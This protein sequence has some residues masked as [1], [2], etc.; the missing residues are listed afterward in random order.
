MPKKKTSI[1]IVGDGTA[2]K[3]AVCAALNDLYESSTVIEN[4]A[5]VWPPDDGAEDNSSLR[6]IVT[7]IV[8]TATVPLTVF[9]ESKSDI[10]KHIASEADEIVESGSPIFAACSSVGRNVT[11]LVL[12]NDDNLDYTEKV[13]LFL[14]QNGVKEILDL[15]NALVPIVVEDDEA[16]AE[17]A[18]PKKE[19]AEAPKAEKPEA[20]TEDELL[21]MPVATL[22]LIA[23]NMGESFSS[24]PSKQELVDL[25]LGG[26]STTPEEVLPQKEEPQKEEPQPVAAPQ[27]NDATMVVFYNNGSSV[28]LN[29]S[30]AAAK[31]AVSTIVANLL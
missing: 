28:T 20:F 12:W 16:P 24:H 19:P 15:T 23:T 3:K 31:D 5:L 14:A 2:P 1:I 7:W 26:G 4:V 22:K 13:V 30:S 10:P 25:I 29:L 27:Q 9:A 8:D 17:K 18:P 11:G 6:E 21:S